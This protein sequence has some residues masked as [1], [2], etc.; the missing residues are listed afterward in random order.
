MKK[1][2]STIVAAIVA[3]SFAGIVLAAEPATPATPTTPAAG[4]MKRRKSSGEKSE[5]SEKTSQ[6]NK[7]IQ[8][9]DEKRNEDGKRS[10]PC[11]D[12]RRQV[13]LRKHRNKDCRTLS[14]A[15]FFISLFRAIKYPAE[16]NR[17]SS[18]VARFPGSC[19]S[20]RAFST[21][22]MILPL[23]VLGSES[24]ISIFSGFAMGPI[25]WATC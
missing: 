24:T 1:V 4:E 6:E 14:G 10:G 20:A 5:E 2:L 23:R 7:K 19:P 11:R 8:K 18:S 3:V 12:S 9:T 16:V 15:A 13:I 21:R 22:R 25:S 17:Y